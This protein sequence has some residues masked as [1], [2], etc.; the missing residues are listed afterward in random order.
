MVGG[1]HD[2]I[3]IIGKNPLNEEAFS[4]FAGDDDFPDCLFAQIQPQLSFSHIGIRAVAR[5]AIICKNGPYIAV[6]KDAI[7]FGQC[8]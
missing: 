8:R 6:K 7:G 1:G 2:L 5:P 3:E 4:S